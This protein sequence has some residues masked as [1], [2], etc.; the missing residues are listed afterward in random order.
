MW[1]KVDFIRQLVMTSS[2]VG[3]R[4]SSKAPKAKL[5]PRTGH[6]HCLLVCC[7]SDPLQLSESWQN[8]YI[9]E[10]CSANWWDALKT[11]MPAADTDQ[12]NGPNSFPWQRPTSPC[13][14]NSSITE[15][16]GLWSFASSAIFTWP[17]TNQLSLL[18]A[19]GQL[20]AGKMLPQPAGCR[21]CLPRVNWILKHGFLHYKVICKH[22]YF[23]LAKM[24]WL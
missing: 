9:W 22:T 12:Q 8:H 17:L 5:V 18:Q 2:V 24:C 21:K 6:G 13:I 11:A 7:Q 4:R 20:F 16:I 1:W 10:V 19:S 23:L 3:L 15:W 14:T